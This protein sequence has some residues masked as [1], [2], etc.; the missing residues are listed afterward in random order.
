MQLNTKYAKITWD[1]NSWFI[2]NLTNAFKHKVSALS[3]DPS[4]I[5]VDN[6]MTFDDLTLQIIKEKNYLFGKY[7][8]NLIVAI[9]KTVLYDNL[10]NNT[11][12]TKIRNADK[13]VKRVRQI[14]CYNRY[15]RR[16]YLDVNG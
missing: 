10:D 16:G 4:V 13:E 8:E 2:N 5:L 15:K 7:E 6:P 12:L 14:L 3:S 11:L 9:A 1:M